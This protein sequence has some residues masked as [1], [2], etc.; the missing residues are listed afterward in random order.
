MGGEKPIFTLC[1]SVN[2]HFYDDRN[3]FNKTD[4]YLDMLVLTPFCADLIRLFSCFVWNIHTKTQELNCEIINTLNIRRI[5]SVF[6]NLAHIVRACNFKLPFLQSSF[7]CFSKVKL[8]SI[9]MPRN[10]S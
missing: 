3:L 4:F 10:F 5:F 1:N 8:L 7:I 2:K 9:V 6:M